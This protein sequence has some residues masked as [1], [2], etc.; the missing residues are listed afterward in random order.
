MDQY[1]SRLKLSENFERHWSILISRELHMDQSL[2][3]TFSWGNSYGTMVLKL[4]LKF[5]LALVLVHRRHFPGQ[6]FLRTMP[7]LFLW[8]VANRHRNRKRIVAA[9]RGRNHTH[10]HTLRRS[11]CPSLGRLYTRAS[12]LQ[13]PTGCLL[14]EAA[15][16]SMHLPSRDAGC[17][18]E[19]GRTLHRGL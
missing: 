10:T 3:H 5:P 13:M 17:M 1:R 11:A 9:G 7:S 6:P 18:H 15:A 12:S 19:R 14:E 4:L 8:R 2:V 16:R